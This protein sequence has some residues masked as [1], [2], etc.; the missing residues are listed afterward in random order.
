MIIK[1][2]K[3]SL[4]KVVVN[5]DVAVDVASGSNFF[6]VVDVSGSMSSDLPKIRTQLKN[7][8]TLLLKE[9]DRISIVWFS[10]DSQCGVL[11][12]NVQVSSLEQMDKLH[13]AIDRFL[14][15]VGCTA[16][17]KPLELVSDIIERTNSKNPNSL[18][19]L[20][21]GYNN[22]CRWSDVISNLKA[23][24]SKLASATFVEYGY[25]ADSAAM[26]EMAEVVGGDK[27]MSSSFDAFDTDF[28]HKL[29]NPITSS[30]K[31]L[32]EIN[33]VDKL[34]YPFAFALSESNDIVLY[35]TSNPIMAAS[36]IKEVYYFNTL[37][38][39]CLIDDAILYVAAFVLGDKIK[40]E[41]CEDVLCALGDIKFI[42]SYSTAF[43][44]QRLFSFLAEIKEAIT[45][46][47]KRFVNGKDLNYVIDDNAYC[48][49]NL[50]NDLQKVDA[51]FY[52]YHPA[53]KY[54]RISRA[55]VAAPL[56]LSDDNKTD[57]SKVETIDELKDLLKSIEESKGETDLKFTIYDKAKGY[58]MTDLVYNEKRAN[59]SVRVK[60]DGFVEF[61]PTK[62]EFGLDKVDTFQ[63]KTY[64]IIK[65]AMV[66]V[67]SIVVGFLSDDDAVKIGEKIGYDSIKN[68]ITESFAN[69][70]GRK[71]CILNI[72]N[73][74]L[75]NRS[76]Y[77]SLSAKTLAE[78]QYKLE[79]LKAVNKV[80]NT[81]KET[82]KFDG[83]AEIY[84]I[85]AAT[86]LQSLGF[87][88]ASGF[89]PLKVQAEA[90]DSYVAQ[91]LEVKIAGLSSL[92]KVEDVKTK[93]AKNPEKLT[94]SDT[95]IKE[96][97][98]ELA[99][100]QKVNE[101]VLK[102]NPEFASKF[103]QEKIKSLNVEKREL[104]AEKA[105]QIF[106]LIASRKWFDEF[107][108]MDEDTLIVDI[109]GK[110]IKVKFDY[111]QVTENI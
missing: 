67:E 105:Q 88:D 13:K 87:T 82:K 28:S 96:G 53:F 40:V 76:M 66:N 19:F 10:G 57:L 49:L 4:S 29:S 5:H 107:K 111:K 15:P 109:G 64:N 77:K 101:S 94:L 75:I 93:A 34:K 16:F 73:L 85:E 32:I 46:K 38:D 98:D 80:F 90:I 81:E 110:E 68:V 95:L 102:I 74:P 79:R 14:K 92:P 20:T 30:K 2:N 21:D 91:S 43:G 108:S 52:P 59:L 36:N 8:L 42:Q 27:I 70:D 100:M 89:A 1:Q 65:D 39:N 106:T 61:N 58:Q 25:Y 104:M 12:E 9:E 56:K 69:K 99:L 54:N 6:F 84:G 35:N 45:D 24:E 26:S 11:Q 3:L 22:D 83:L 17:R 63:Y 60:V 44:K 55:T 86:W 37:E 7:K 23:L 48:V 71:V 47:T 97:I 51:L 72:E 18:I 78:T 33:D 62:N 31:T 41:D 103:M 50:I